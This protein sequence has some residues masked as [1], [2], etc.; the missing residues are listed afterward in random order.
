[1]CICVRTCF[2]LCAAVV[3]QRRSGTTTRVE[4]GLY[5]TTWLLHSAS[6]TLT[7]SIVP[8]RK[9]MSIHKAPTP[10]LGEYPSRLDESSNQNMFNSGGRF[11][12]TTSWEAV[13]SPIAQ[14]F[15]VEDSKMADVFP[16]A[17]NFPSGE[18]FPKEALF[19]K[20]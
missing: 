6:M 13:W 1:M 18:I 3:N 15:G 8:N 2:F 16:N 17:A 14:W 4:H 10:S 19:K 11:I 5:T 7:H 20:A 12:P 9:Y